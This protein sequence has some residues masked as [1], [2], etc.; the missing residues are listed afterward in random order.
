ML[1]LKSFMS[2]I[3]PN[4]DV[5]PDVVCG[6]KSEPGN[7]ADL[8]NLLPPRKKFEVSALDSLVTK[9]DT[10]PVCLNRNV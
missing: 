2:K 9:S 3:L 7:F 10:V 8:E 1:L 6:T 5:M 4:C